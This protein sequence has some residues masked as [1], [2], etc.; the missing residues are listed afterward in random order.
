MTHTPVFTIATNGTAESIMEAA[1]MAASKFIQETGEEA[2]HAWLHPS[3][4]ATIDIDVFRFSTDLD[5]LFDPQKKEPHH[6][7]VG[8]LPD[9]EPM[10]SG[11]KV[12]G[13]T[14]NNMWLGF[15]V[16]D[17]GVGNIIEAINSTKESFVERIGV[18]PTHVALHGSFEAKKRAIE[19]E[20]GLTT[21]FDQPMA[22]PT[23]GN[24]GVREFGAVSL[25]V[26]SSSNIKSI[27]FYSNGEDDG[28][29]SMFVFFSRESTDDTDSVYIYDD[30]P[31]E[32]YMD[33]VSSESKGEF[34]SKH[35]KKKFH[36]SKVV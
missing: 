18:V 4:E 15:R 6:L 12:L 28:L 14:R 17:P 33:F 16:N 25:Q 31:Y 27:E 22:Y 9:T 32:T 23:W 26:K 8:I 20:T 24:V 30:V 34:F 11:R 21:I 29:G 13:P 10:G 2:T 3:W 19:D 1:T 36:T 35:I 7:S 5:P